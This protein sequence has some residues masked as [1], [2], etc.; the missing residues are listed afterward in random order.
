MVSVYHLCNDRIL[1]DLVSVRGVLPDFNLFALEIHEQLE[2][3]EILAHY[4]NLLL[5]L[6]EGQLRIELSSVRLLELDGELGDVRIC[7]SVRLDLAE[8][9]VAILGYHS[10]EHVLHARFVLLN[11][12]DGVEVA[13]LH[14]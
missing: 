13:V 5:L 12:K 3:A 2:N 9:K 14:W 1:F 11:P 4:A 10:A 8:D 7:D 6:G